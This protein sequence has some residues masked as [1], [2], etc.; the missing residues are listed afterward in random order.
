MICDNTEK[1]DGM[2]EWRWGEWGGMGGRFKSEGTHVI[3]MAD[4]CCGMAL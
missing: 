1:W 2:G 3:P 4:S